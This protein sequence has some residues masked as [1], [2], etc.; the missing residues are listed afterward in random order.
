METTIKDLILND[1]A[2]IETRPKTKKAP[3]KPAKYEI[4]TVSGP[5]F[6]VRKKGTKANYL[7]VC[8]CSKGQFYIRNEATGETEQL[9]SSA[10]TKF[11]N[12][13]PKDS[14][15]DLS[16]G[17][18]NSPFW[19]TGLDRTRDFAENFMSAVNDETIRQYFCKNML[20]FSGIEGYVEHHRKARYRSPMNTELHKVDF[21]RA[22]TIFECAA[23]IYPRSDVKD[24][25]AACLETGR[26]DGKIGSMFQVLLRT[27]EQHNHYYT[28]RNTKTVYDWLFDNW[29]IEGVK[30]FI[31]S[32]L[33]TPVAYMPEN[34]ESSPTIQ[35]TSFALSEFVDY[36]FCEWCDLFPY[37]SQ[38][39]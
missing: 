7:L 9:D 8:I 18:G 6:A 23:E 37:K 32:Y 28:W 5:D 24:G 15:L 16:D 33:E 19:I 17:S 38:M 36:S 13:V 26:S 4:V 22:K 10:L 12:D 35:K 27:Y 25:L 20:T 2:I 3:R 29:G 31:R 14:L 1:E 21:K 39:R 34:L 11:L 30:Q